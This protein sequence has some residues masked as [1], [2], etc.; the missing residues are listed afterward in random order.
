MKMKY[1]LSSVVLFT[2]LINLKAKA[3]T[4]TEF[5]SKYDNFGVS[6]K[7]KAPKKV[8]INSFNVLVEVYRED[9]DYKAE[10]EFRG[11]GRAEAT[12]S[13]ALGIVGVDTG[14]LQSKTDQLFNEL[15]EDLKS[16]GFEIVGIEEAKRTKYFKNA[17]P[18]NGPLVRESANPGL[19]EVVPSNFKG[20]TTEKNAEG[21]ESK[22]SGMFPGMKGL[23]KLT[24]NTNMLSDQ[25]DDAIVIDVN[26]ALTWS[27]TGSSWL[28]EMG[29]ANAKIET[30][31]ALG[32]KTVSAPKNKNSK[33]K[34]DYYIIP[35]DFTVAQGSGLK[36]VTWKG[37]LKKPI[38]IQGVMENEKI[39]VYNKGQVAKTYDV[40]NMFRVTEWTSTIS[41][42]AKF[43]EVDGNKFAD[44][45]Y[46][47]ADSFLKD[48]LNYF[49][50]QYSK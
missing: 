10:R 30:N 28:K 50:D 4:I 47:S 13:A 39:E 26:L 38:G 40:G 1:I 14:M 29:G 6:P 18:F 3:Q 7:K 16:N 43:V 45:L 31:L 41:E 21:K 15:L 20:F 48:Q 5:K 35:N 46:I 24:K 11:K 25:L 33:G 42:N 27:K 37:Y 12:A 23:G 32:E 8:Y 49:Y 19:L 34:E 22:K 9:V 36:K 2:V 44:A 17:V